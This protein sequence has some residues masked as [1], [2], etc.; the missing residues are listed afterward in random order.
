MRRISV[1]LAC[2]GVTLACAQP[3]CLAKSAVVIDARSGRTLFDQNADEALPPASTT[4]IL[5][6]LVVARRSKMDET[7]YVPADAVGIEGSSFHLRPAEAFTVRD[8]LYA[9]MLRSGN[10]VAHTLAVHIAGSDESFA[11]LM[12]EEAGKLGCAR[13]R[14]LNPHGLP[15]PGHVT[16]ARDLA[17]IAIEAL[18]DEELAKIVGT[19][20]HFVDRGAASKDTLL[21]NRNTWLKRDPSAIG[22][23][24]GRTKEAGQCFVGA[25]ERPEGKIVTAILGSTNWLTDQEALVAYAF[26]EFQESVVASAGDEVGR[27]RVER[28][29]AETVSIGVNAEF[30]AMTRD[31]EEWAL[32]PEVTVLRA[33]VALGSSVG[34]GVFRAPDGFE[35][36]VELVALSAVDESFLSRYGYW[37]FGVLSASAVGLGL[38]ALR[39]RRAA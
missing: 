2:L 3:T 15:G 33:P 28:G 39:A 24:T 18:Q 1:A 34:K 23:K 26:S 7:V 30:R 38:L 12:N 20:R 8:L 14:F 37:L 13:S 16:S 35:A 27:I 17:R 4:K 36:E 25:A 31:G 11:D 29:T 5:T 9:L 21:E 32:V 6:A 19:Q 10:D 22:V